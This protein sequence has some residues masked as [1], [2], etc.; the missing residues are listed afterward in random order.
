[1]W[2]G[3]IFI[4]YQTPKLDAV[5]GLSSHNIADVLVS[6]TLGFEALMLNPRILQ[7]G[8]KSGSS[9]MDNILVM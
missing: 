4:S 7:L 2:P 6:A 8:D 1:V 3:Y 9:A 5:S